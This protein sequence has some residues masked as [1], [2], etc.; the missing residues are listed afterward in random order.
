MFVTHYG[1]KSLTDLNE[2]C[3][4]NCAVPELA[5]ERFQTFIANV[6]AGKSLFTILFLVIN[7]NHFTFH[8]AVDIHDNVCQQ[9]YV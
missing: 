5:H 4:I 2:I 1:E 6:A 8:T 9:R 7:V 3:W